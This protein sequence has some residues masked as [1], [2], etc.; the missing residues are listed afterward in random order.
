MREGP[1]EKG[2]GQVCWGEKVWSEDTQCEVCLGAPDMENWKTVRS[3][4]GMGTGV[5]RREVM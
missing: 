1:R 5:R 2:M 3:S 4:E